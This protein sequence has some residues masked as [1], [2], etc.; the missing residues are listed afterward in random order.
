LP[1]LFLLCALSLSIW[2]ATTD[3]LIAQAHT[4]NLS[5]TPYWHLLMH[6]PKDENEIDDDAFFMAKDRKYNLVSELDATI[7]HLTEDI[8][9]S[10]ESLFCRFPAR[11]AWLEHE[12]NVSF[13]Q[14]EC[15]AYDALVAKMD[16]QKVTLVFPTAHINSPA[17]MFGHTFLRIDSSME[18]KL[19]S[20]CLLYTSPSPRD[21]TRS[22]MPSSA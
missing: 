18:S 11:R 21:R 13:G 10:D 22:R 14:G 5:Q 12:L 16:P 4:L 7:R 20:Y 1:I 17:S 15:H 19:M 9:R 8:N 6:C 2:S 3:E